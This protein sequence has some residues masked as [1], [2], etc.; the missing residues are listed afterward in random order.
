MTVHGG[1]RSDV[2]LLTRFPPRGVR[3]R[4][5]VGDMVQ[6]LDG[7]GIGACARACRAHL[8]TSA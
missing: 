1:T 2:I 6:N 8:R 4:I 7:D 5:V 3:K